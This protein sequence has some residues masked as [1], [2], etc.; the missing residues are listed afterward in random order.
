MVML[1][2][3]ELLKS[4]GTRPPF[5]EFPDCSAQESIRLSQRPLLPLSD[6]QDSGRGSSAALPS[7]EDV[8]ATASSWAV[9]VHL[10]NDSVNRVQQE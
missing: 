5:I 2:K 6:S 1:Q 10:S 7:Q 3:Q 9:N 4:P 8:V